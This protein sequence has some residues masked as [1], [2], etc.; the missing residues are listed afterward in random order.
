MAEFEFHKQYNKDLQRD[1]LPLVDLASVCYPLQRDDLPFLL[2][3]I[4]RQRLRALPN[5]RA[6]PRLQPNAL[7]GPGVLVMARFPKTT[8]FYRACVVAPPSEP[9]E[10]CVKG[11][12]EIRKPRLWVW[13]G[14]TL[15]NIKKNKI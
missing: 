7:F 5:A 9:N 8:V 3:R 13:G 2:K 12:W 4:R 10:G 6:H 15:F 1:N 11:I 14:V